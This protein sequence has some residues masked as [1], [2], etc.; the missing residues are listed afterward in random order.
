MVSSRSSD[1]I[2]AIAGQL[3]LIIVTANASLDWNA[4]IGSLGPKGRLHIVGAVL[5]PIPVQAFSLILG[6]KEVSGSGRFF[7]RL[8]CHS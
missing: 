5:E 3:D 8:R 2:K 1:E 4:F 7:N 6:Q